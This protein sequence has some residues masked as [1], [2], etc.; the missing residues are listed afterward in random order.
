L[1]RPSTG[2]DEFLEAKVRPIAGVLDATLGAGFEVK[3]L[4]FDE[5]ATIGGEISLLV[6]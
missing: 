3:F 4:G 1:A 2:V 6:S 5:V